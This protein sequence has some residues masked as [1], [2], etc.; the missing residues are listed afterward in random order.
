MVGLLVPWPGVGHEERA[1]METVVGWASANCTPSAI[2]A[3]SPGCYM[4]TVCC[5]S[6]FYNSSSPHCVEQGKFQTRVAHATLCWRP[7]G[8]PTFILSRQVYICAMSP[9]HWAFCYC[10]TLC[11][12]TRFLPPFQWYT[13]MAATSA[14]STHSSTHTFGAR[15]LRRTLIW[16]ACLRRACMR[17]YI[18]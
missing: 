11:C 15:T 13:F 3:L 5:C 12:I 1:A 8:I 7:F 4:R 17:M 18:G 9:L 2:D 10:A 14:K 6:T 16:A